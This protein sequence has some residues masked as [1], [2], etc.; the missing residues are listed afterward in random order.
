MLGTE[1]VEDGL[2]RIEGDQRHLHEHRIPVTH[3]AVPETWQFL[4]LQ[5]TAL[6]ALSA[7]KAGLRINK[8]LQVEFP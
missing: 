3:R 5:R 7:D 1:Q 8:A 4:G 2:D 6:V